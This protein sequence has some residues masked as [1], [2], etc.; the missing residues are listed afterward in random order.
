MIDLS[1]L[2]LETNYDAFKNDNVYT[3]SFTISGVTAPGTNV[4]TF[5]ATLNEA[6]DMV[7]VVFNGASGGLNP[8]PADGWFT[9]GSITVPTD[10]AGGGNPSYW[11]LYGSI[12]GVTLTITA[13]YVQQFL[14]PEA[15]TSTDF[16]YRLVDYS[17][18]G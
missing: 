8:R 1:L 16:S 6:P 5:N 14:T 7:D 12:S 10:N 13:V 2:I 11:Q 17:I 4:Q 3:G 18:F 9:Q 15:L